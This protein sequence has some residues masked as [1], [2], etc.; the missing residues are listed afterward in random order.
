M[1]DEKHCKDCEFFKIQDRP[2][3]MNEG[4]VLCTKHNLIIELFTMNKIKKL[5]CAEDSE[6]E[7]VE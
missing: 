5:K 7:V 6:S 2:D 3:D 1:V 4:H